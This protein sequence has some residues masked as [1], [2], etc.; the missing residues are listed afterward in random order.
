MSLT[1]EV[2][3]AGLKLGADLVGIAPI[4][5]FAGAPPPGMEDE[6]LP[7]PPI[8]EGDEAVPEI[9]S[10]P[11][12]EGELPLLPPDV[13]VLPPTEEEAAPLMPAVE[14]PT[15]VP[16]EPPATAP[17]E[18]AV[19]E[20]P[21][22][23]E[24]GIVLNFQDASVDAV[25]AYL[26]EAAGFIVIKAATVTGRVSIVSLQPLSADEAVTLLNSVLKDK[27]CAAIRMGRVLK[28]VPLADAKKAS[29]PVRYGNDP[30]VIEPTD[31]VVT[32]V[33]PLRYVDA[34]RLKAD[35]APLIPTYAD[36][37]SNVSSNALIMTDTQANIRRVV[38][39]VRA[40]DTT[41]SAVTEVK[42]FQLKYANATSAAR[43][44]NE[45]FRQ[46]AQSQQQQRGGFAAA[47]RRFRGPGAEQAASGGE[48][49]VE[50]KVTASADDRTNALVVSA[51]PDVLRVVENVVRDLDAN[52]AAEQEVFLY[53]L[54][55]ADAA[56][57]EEV[58]NDL[59]AE[60]Q[61]RSTTSRGGGTT[62]G[63]RTARTNRGQTPSTQT[64]AATSD[65]AGEVYVV[66]EEDTNS[67]MVMTASKNVER[68]K[69]IIAELDRS[70]PQVLIKVLLAE[71]TH[72]NKRDLGAEFSALN[73][74]PSGRGG[75]I[76]TDFAIAAQTDGAIAKLVEQDVTVALRAL[77]EVGTLDVLSRPYIL[78]SDNQ[79]ATITVGQEVP[80]IRNT[81]TTDTGQTINTIEYEDIGIILNVT[82]HINPDGLV[83]MDVTPEIS[84]LT[85]DTVPI[86]ENVEAP[87][88]AKRSAECHVAIQNGQTIVIG[89]LME[90]TKTDTIR[91]VPILGSIPGIGAFFRRTVTNKSKTELL[92][93][94]TPHVAE[95]AVL[96]Q[97]MSKDEQN[98][99]VILPKAIAPGAFDRHME[100]MQRGAT[101]EDGENRQA[102]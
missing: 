33:I 26:S 98:G 63:G 46:D 102:P 80:F 20:P 6:V 25:L 15:V 60:E 54:K 78:T 93:F 86:S 18:T 66:A 13:E 69:E 71:V 41:L 30:E 76:F 62:R 37:S 29:I 40:L 100:G 56:N 31:E 73:I 57:M 87:V 58:L 85:G 94:M 91:K 7:P 90:D 22:P 48:G 10:P 36:L 8:A 101:P 50:Q 72:S 44:V 45:I 27:N 65:L 19:Q 81:R 68:V 92:I 35:I 11:E 82:P 47:F 95:E 75:Q 51:P 28:I 89:G 39:I 34:V 4:G 52:P 97:E 38:E 16:Y 43:L 42:V 70:S 64:T 74:R 96:L 9:P 83:I 24:G 67:L 2:K 1:G 53:R 12:E 88:F 21:T 32:Q 55:N 79:A 59:F 14:E 17:V 61:S 84:T 77:E 99:A 3:E 5:R 49:G 23:V